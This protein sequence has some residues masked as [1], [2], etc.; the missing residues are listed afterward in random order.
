MAVGEVLEMNP[1]MRCSIVFF[2]AL[3]MLFAPQRSLHAMDSAPVLR[4][5]CLDAASFPEGSPEPLLFSY[6]KRYLNEVAR[7]T[8]W[9]YEYV[10]MDEWTAREMLR[11]GR[12]DMYFPAR[13][14]P[15]DEAEFAFSVDG[16]AYSILSLY[17]REDSTLEPDNPVALANLTV[18]V[19]DDGLHSYALSPL[20]REQGIRV[21]VVE[22]PTADALH[23]ALARGEVDAILDSASR[24]KDGEKLLLRVALM[25]AKFIA[26][27]KREGLM[28]NLSDTILYTERVNPSFETYLGEAFLDRAQN[29]LVRF[30][31][32]EN[33]YLASAPPLR[34]AYVGGHAP[35]FG[36]RLEGGVPEGIYPSLLQALGEDLGLQFRFVRA[37]DNEQALKMLRG[38]EADIFFCVYN[39]LS[40]MQDLLFTATF[41]LEDFSYVVRRGAGDIPMGTARV[42]L[43]RW[44]H[45]MRTYLNMQHPN[46]QI[47]PVDE[48]AD[49]L[50][51]IEEGS[52]DFALLPSLFLQQSSLLSM[53]PSLVVLASYSEE[54]PVSVAISGEQP[55]VLQSVL[56]KGILKMDSRRVQ[57]IVNEHMT[58][59][60]TLTAV[61]ARYPVQS[62]ALAVIFLLSVFIVVFLIERSRVQRRQ[63]EVL[64]AK[65]EELEKAIEEQ[66]KLMRA[67]DIYKQEAEIDPLTGLLNKKAVQAA[68]EEMLAG[69]LKDGAFHAFF[70]MDLD[71]FKEMNDTYGHQAG[72]D[73]LRRFAEDV[74]SIFRQSDHIGR[75]G[76]DE[77]TVL[78]PN[79]TTLVAVEHHARQLMTAAQELEVRDDRSLLSVSIGISLAPMHGTTYDELFMAA[80]SALYDVK[81][82]GRNGW[83]IYDVQEDGGA[84]C[85]K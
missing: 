68:C 9:Q 12:I 6:V 56:T 85:P 75:F 31:T 47:V 16:V 76:G 41:S 83:K 17:V 43:P 67:R 34:V 58:G 38:G 21:D 24:R 80:D 15:G 20:V 51:M 57:E 79:V 19:L 8:G 5:G 78:M 61:V 42:A 82:A 64:L 27:K 18:G 60:L 37:E 74:R 46:W 69:S 40:S 7:S 54:I 48:P 81:R 39:N 53:H 52:C 23:E 72:D 77:F 1:V 55:R 14:M 45:G 33:T 44:F 50:R 59:R 28:K 66:K 73:V 36:E 62:V 32:S 3:V 63:S 30:N 71:H 70:I 49:C 35:F 84:L 13:E 25:P 2:L 4:V 26:A 22:H 29:Q 10:E 11:E 65:N